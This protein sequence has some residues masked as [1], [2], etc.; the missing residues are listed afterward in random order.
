MEFVLTHK[1]GTELNLNSRARCTAVTSAKQSKTLLSAD[2]ITV[3]VTAAAPLD[4]RIGDTLLAFGSTYTLNRL[5][6]CKKGGADVYK[7]TIELEGLQ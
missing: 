5:P 4:L 2:T 6:S 7:Y 3:E 1:D